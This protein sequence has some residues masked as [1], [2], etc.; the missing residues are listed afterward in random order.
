M[1]RSVRTIARGV[2]CVTALAL[3]AAA[4]GD[5]DAASPA[6][7][8]AAAA[9][10]AAGTGSASATTAA[11][12]SATTAAAGGALD[13]DH[14][15]K[16]ASPKDETGSDAAIGTFWGAGLEAATEYVNAHGGILGRKVVVDYKDTQSNPQTASQ[17]TNDMLAG[18]GYQALI[19]TGSGPSGQ[20]ILQAVNKAKILAIGTGPVAEMNDP[21]K[22]PT[23]FD[24]K[25]STTSQG[26]AVGCLAASF[27]PKRVALLHIDDPF[28]TAQIA[29]MKPMFE[30]N[31]IQIV[32]EETYPFTATDITPQVQKIQA[33]KPD[34]L[35]IF[36][37]FNSLSA[38]ITAVKSLNFTNVQ[39]VGDAEMSAA[40][41]ASFLADPND[42]PNSAVAMQWAVNSR[43][44]NT[45]TDRQKT[46]ADLISPKI[47]G[48][49]AAV[50]ATYLY[51]YDALLLVK[52]AAETAKSDKTPDMVKA[53]ESLKEKPVD[54]GASIMATPPYSSTFHGLEG[55]PFY[56]V[57]LKGE[58]VSGTF[59]VI[60]PIPATC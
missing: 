58:Y 26:Q 45:L 47:G 25:F 38:A 23:V 57:D 14:P 34:V 1:R 4:C 48:K 16:I 36:A 54:T 40:P 59:P 10:T 56:G 43:V 15:F 30:K 50:L 39:I 11:G 17:V 44:D 19:P 22:Y 37:Y 18:G 46:A 28:P 29:A 21:T 32:E 35:I 60:K 24:T 8:G 6:T 2:A 9:T 5:D 41:P 49:F 13:S 12:G 52:W 27:S 3:V 31:G 7:T 42:L 51:S 55:A 33:A 20:P 53:L